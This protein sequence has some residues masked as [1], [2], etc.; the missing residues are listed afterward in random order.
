ML[1]TVQLPVVKVYLNGG[2]GKVADMS[3]EAGMACKIILF[4]K[5]KKQFNAERKSFLLEQVCNFILQAWEGIIISQSVVFQLK[6]DGKVI[7]LMGYI[8]NDLFLYHKCK[9]LLLLYYLTL[10]FK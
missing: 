9:T 1:K 3:L 4:K 7:W 10:I 2:Q 5:A 8:K 6:D